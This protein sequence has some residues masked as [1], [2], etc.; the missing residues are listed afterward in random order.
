MRTSPQR[1]SNDE[2][3]SDDRGHQ[4]V[5]E[6]SLGGSEQDPVLR[7]VDGEIVVRHLYRQPL[8]WPAPELLANPDAPADNRQRLLRES[9][10]L[11]ELRPQC[12]GE[13]NARPH[14]PTRLG[15]W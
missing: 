15:R 11:N 6:Q 1:C 13:T 12:P 8:A 10:T 7:R 2:A 9:V 14:R 3:A 5:A 4:G